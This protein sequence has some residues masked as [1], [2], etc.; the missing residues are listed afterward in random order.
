MRE[1]FYTILFMI[2][3]FAVFFAGVFSYKEINTLNYNILSQYYNNIDL[4]ILYE[5]NQMLQEIVKNQKEYIDSKSEK[6]TIPIFCKNAKTLERLEKES[7]EINI[8]DA[9]LISD[10]KMFN[11]CWDEMDKMLKKPLGITKRLLQYIHEIKVFE[12][13]CNKRYVDGIMLGYTRFIYADL[14]C[15]D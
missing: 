3:V 13:K 15:E 2:F 9:P 4:N 11:D 6:L 8:Y 5:E 1:L 7:F 14:K 12:K 10:S